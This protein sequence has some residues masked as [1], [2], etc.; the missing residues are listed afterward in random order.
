[1]EN[2]VR[3]APVII[4]RETNLGGLRYQNLPDA[5]N[6]TQPEP[7]TVSTSFIRPPTVNLQGDFRL[8]VKG[9]GISPY[10][11]AGWTDI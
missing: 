4:L 7:F 1:M 9:Q 11:G 5:L 8:R 10:G 2:R 3:L 6:A